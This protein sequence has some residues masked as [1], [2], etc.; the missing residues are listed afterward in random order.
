MTKEEIRLSL[1]SSLA[2]WIESVASEFECQPLRSGSAMAS[3]VAVRLVPWEPGLPGIAYE[4]D[5]GSIGCVAGGLVDCAGPEIAAKL[6]RSPS[7][8]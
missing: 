4:L 7:I 1:R 2:P 5:D 6:Y 8:R 3:V